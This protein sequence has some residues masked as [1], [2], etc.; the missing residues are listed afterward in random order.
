MKIWKQSLANSDSVK[1]MFC[2][3]G[4][5]PGECMLQKWKKWQNCYLHNLIGLYFQVQQF[6]C[7]EQNLE[8][9]LN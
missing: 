6:Y 1:N 3:N 8:L 5:I 2:Y 9:P 4:L 7:V